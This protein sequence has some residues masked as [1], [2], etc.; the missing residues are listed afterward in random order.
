MLRTELCIFRPVRLA[1]VNSYQMN[2]ENLIHLYSTTSRNEFIRL[3]DHARFF[4]SQKTE[5]KEKSLN[6][7]APQQAKNRLRP[8]HW[9][10]SAY[11]RTRNSI[12]LLPACSVASR[13]AL[14]SA[15]VSFLVSHHEIVSSFSP[16]F[17]PS[18]LPNSHPV[19]R[20]FSTLVSSLLSAFVFQLASCHEILTSPLKRTLKDMQF[21]SLP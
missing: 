17:S 21:F 2:G 7:L 16:H 1:S 6:N 11:L 13:F 9:P 20:R 12:T 15:L 8:V 3:K 14:V 5:V 10:C 4:G 19:T 18:C